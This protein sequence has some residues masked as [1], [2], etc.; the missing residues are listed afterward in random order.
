MILRKAACFLAV[1]GALALVAAACG[2]PAAAPVKTPSGPPH[3]AASSQLA[4]GKYL[5]LAAGCNDCHTGGP[6]DASGGKLPTS[7]WLEGNRVGFDMGPPFGTTYAPNLRLKISQMTQQQF[8]KLFRESPQQSGIKPP[9]PIMDYVYLSNQDL[10]AIYAFI[11][12][13]GPAGKAM[14][15]DLPPGVTPKTPYVIM[16]PQNLPKS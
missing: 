16:Y 8:L 13:L 6:W 10:K 1:G 7:K 12:S 4:A 5:V 2:T 14:P 3:V 15:K 9:M 11:K